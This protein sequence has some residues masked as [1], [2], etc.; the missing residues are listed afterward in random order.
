MKQLWKPTWRQN[1]EALAPMIFAGVLTLLIL[2]GCATPTIVT[3]TSCRAFQPIYLG[4]PTI[5]F[6]AGQP[7]DKKKIADH[8]RIWERLCLIE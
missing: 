5:A 1:V 4:E 3:D 8:N 7:D 6:L 2:D